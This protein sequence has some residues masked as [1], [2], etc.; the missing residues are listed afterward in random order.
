MGVILPK[1]GVTEAGKPQYVSDVHGRGQLNDT[2]KKLQPKQCHINITECR[3]KS[4]YL[5]L[6]KEFLKGN[7][8]CC[9]NFT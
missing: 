2:R 8:M 1:Q 9:L 5:N 4:L 3:T 6:P 7:E